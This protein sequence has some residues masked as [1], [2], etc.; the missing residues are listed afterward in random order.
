MSEKMLAVVNYGAEP[1]SVELREI[2]VPEIG[3]TDVLLA[4]RAVGICGSDLHQFL[5]K[6]SW[7]VNYPVVLGHEFSGVI[8][9]KGKSVRGFGEGDRVVSE[10]AAQIDSASPFCRQGLYNLDPKRLGFGY[11]VDPVRWTADRVN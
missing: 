5:G 7:K 3:E 10:T 6:H 9:K 1:K 4:V 8:A 11:E 2:P